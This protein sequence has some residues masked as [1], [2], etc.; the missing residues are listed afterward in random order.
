VSHTGSEPPPDEEPLVRIAARRTARRWR[1]D[2]ATPEFGRL[3]LYQATAAA[4]DAL[5]ALGL[6]GSLFFAVPAADARDRVA[7]YLLL[8]MAPFAIVAPFLA[9]FLD[10]HRG[11]M[12]MLMIV[13]S[14]GRGCLAWLLS[15]RIDSLY[16]FPLAFGILV[17]SRAGLV[18]RGAILPQL[19]PEGRSLVNANALLSK[20]SAIAGMVVGL[21]GV[22]LLRWP[23]ESTEL[24]FAAAVYFVGLIPAIGLPRVSGRRGLED[25]M[26]ARRAVRSAAVRQAVLATTGIRFF[27]GFLVM[28]LAFA[29]KR[30]E[31]GG[32]IG[33]GL[34]I[35]A[36]ATGGLFGA[37]LAP[38]LRR[39]LK[40]EGILVTSLV[41]AGIAGLVVGRYFSAV[42]A[43]VLVF[44]FG[45]AAGAAKVAF[46]SIV[47]RETPE[48]ARGWAFA[49][50]EAGLQFA[51][52][53]GALIPI[54]PSIPAG[55]GVFAVGIAANLLALIYIA[56]RHRLRSQMRTA[57]QARDSI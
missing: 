5:I 13:A 36:A 1:A 46:D 47:Q 57:R 53:I 50:F 31:F 10:R 40:E 22:L 26:G 24:L 20:V 7:L 18:V 11:G 42:T 21:P 43:G 54:L 30:D 16:L 12:K 3:L 19:I 9:A 27:V 55:S 39:R 32:S 48:G 38:R 14:L 8:T 35:G 52:V 56:G 44:A 6:A 45:V 37:L 17:L 34:L 51:W 23:G 41:I 15:T 4:G 2:A 49:R 33:L 29:V 28:H 25:R